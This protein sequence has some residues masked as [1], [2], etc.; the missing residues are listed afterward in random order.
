MSLIAIRSILLVGMSF[1]LMSNA[2]ADV[3]VF[4]TSRFGSADWAEP[5]DT[6]NDGV[7]DSNDVFPNDPTETSDFDGDGIGDNADPDDDNDGVAD[8]SDALPFDAT[9]SVDTDGD[10]VGNNADTDDDNDGLSDA[11]EGELGTDPLLIDTDSDGVN[12]LEDEY[13][14][15]PSESADS[16]GDGVADG[17]DAFPNNAS[18][19]TDTDG[20][21][22]GNN[23]DTDDDNDG[24]SDLLDPEPLIDNTAEL[25]KYELVKIEKTYSLASTYAAERGAHLATIS[26]EKENALVY[27]IVSKAFSESPWTFREV[28]DGGGIA[29]VWLGGSDLGQE[30]TWA[31]ETDEVFSY[32]NWGSA[33][34]DN[35]NANQDSLAMGLEDWPYWLA[36][37][38]NTYGK[39]SEWN[40]ISADNTIFFVMETEGPVVDTDGDGII[41]SMDAFPNDPTETTDSDA[42]GVGDNADAFPNDAAETTDSDGDGVGDNSDWAPNDRSETA[43]SDGDGVGDNADDFPDDSTEQL[44]TDGDGI[45]NNTD[46]DDD[47]DGIPDEDDYYPLDAN[48]YRDTDGDGVG[49]Q[50]DFDDDGDGVPDD[51]DVAPLDAKRPFTARLIGLYAKYN[52]TWDGDYSAPGADFET[53]VENLSLIDVPV[54]SWAIYDGDANK[55]MEYTSNISG[56]GILAVGEA[57]AFIARFSSRGL[58]S[59]VSFIYTFVDPVTGTEFIKTAKFTTQGIDRDGDDILD[60]DDLFPDNVDEWKDSDGDGIGDNQDQLPLDS[61]DYLDN[62]NDGIGNSRDPDIDGDGVLNAQDPFPN[63]SEYIADSDGDGMPDSWETRYNL[64]PNDSSDAAMDED[65]DGATNLEEFLAGTPPSGSLDIDGNGE[66]DALTDGLL[67]LRGM[68]GLTDSALIAGAVASEAVYTSSEELQ[69]RITLLGDLADIDGN[70][71][72]DALTDGLLT[73]RYLFGLEGNTLITGVVASDA[74]RT[75]A[76]DIEAHLKTLMPAL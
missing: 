36:G 1:M 12:D 76:A 65:S 28:N 73:L 63:Q 67:L 49:D 75:S 64:N 53:G 70:G 72:I 23:A 47:D 9:E 41:D 44:D 25:E 68:F 74:T 10:G 31:W 7:S 3:G 13:P 33:E 71:E 57:A 38:N 45:G 60:G 40:D 29:Y 43:D 11:E 8:V 15:D 37:T 59:P 21:G 62:D 17:I 2:G 35:Y 54:K 39:A 58:L 22:E 30:G 19:D 5:L 6:D 55:E 24:I 51:K 46:P 20:D 14:L 50:F 61:N 34:P 27:A 16:D 32:A 56:D 69:T 48:N 18:E 4:G 52:G 66:Y 42:D 26:N